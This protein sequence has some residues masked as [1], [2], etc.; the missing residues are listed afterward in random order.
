MDGGGV[1]YT[2]GVFPLI[3]TG[4]ELVEFRAKEEDKHY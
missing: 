1:D 2:A 3:S 4:S